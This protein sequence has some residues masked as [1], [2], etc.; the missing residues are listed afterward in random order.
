M[1]LQST[2]FAAA[3]IA[4]LFAFSAAWAQTKAPAKSEAADRHRQED[5]AKHRKLARAHD[6]AAKCLESGEKESVCHEKM[7]A[8]C[9]GIA[10]GKFCGMKHSH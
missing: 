8:T 9:A 7:R 2:R 3:V 1:K 6:E 10:I 5:V 4:A